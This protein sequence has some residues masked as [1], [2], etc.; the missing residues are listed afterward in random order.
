[1]LTLPPALLFGVGGSGEF[2]CRFSGFGDPRIPPIEL[3]DEAC[4]ECC[5][6][7][8]GG[9]RVGG[10]G[11]GGSME[12]VVEVVTKDKGSV[13]EF[14]EFTRELLI[15]IFWLFIFSATRSA[16][17]AEDEVDAEIIAVVAGDA[18]KEANGIA[19]VVVCE[20]T[21]TFTT[22]IGWICA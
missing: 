7:G 6:V 21:S 16:M 18:P 14:V 8:G 5:A 11:A 20:L 2:A 4:L 3:E 17:P 9:G 10:G 13:D 12:V 15:L 22:I 1:M 19:V